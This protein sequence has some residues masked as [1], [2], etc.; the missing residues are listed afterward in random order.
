M[1]SNLY[2]SL[3]LSVIAATL[4]LG[5][6]LA[7]SAPPAAAAESAEARSLN[8]LR[9][10]VVNLLNGLVERGVITR[11]QAEQMVRDAQTAATASEAQ[12]QARDQAEQGAVRV[13]YVPEIVKQ[14]IRKQVKEDLAAEVSK[15]VVE[16]A[17]SEGWGVPAALPDW[18]RRMRWYGDMRL[19]GQ[20]DLFADDNATLTYIDFQRV[21][22][23]GGIGR[24]GLSAFSNTTEERYRMRARLRLGFETQLGYGWTMGAR[25]TTGNLRDPVS[26][27]QTL[28]NTGARYQST[29]DLAWIE[30][31][32]NSATARH[33]FTTTG[34][35]TRN[36]WFAASDLVWDQDLNFEGVSANYRLGL[37]RDDPY[38]HFAYLTVGAF[39]LQEVE[40]ARDKWLLGGQA[41]FDWKFAT[42][43]RLR[44]GA[45]YY[46]Y[47]NTEG[48]RNAFDSTLLDYTAPQFV[49]RGNT[50]FDIRSDN[51]SNTNLF[52]L[53]ASYKL[54]DVS[55]VYDWRLNPEYRLSLGADYV[56]NVGYDE[57]EVRARTGFSVPA[58]V[59]G[60][61]GEVAFG[62]AV[63]ARVNGWR[64][65]AG[66]RYLERDA[67]LDAFTDSDFRLGGTDTKGYYVGG[68]FYF[69]PRVF[70]RLKYLSANEIDGPPL[71]IDN[72]QL[73]LTASF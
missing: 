43:S 23:A 33:V 14:E 24:A 17:T 40:L 52:A 39:P 41:G 35:R 2:P 67:V 50:L 29:F 58:R 42:G 28:G 70:A 60:Y 19:R 46:G 55:V 26:T 37:M 22:E 18:V 5:A 72:V 62:T 69:S 7:V 34:G 57:A 9:N 12:V 71:G 51:D 68:D 73:D 48:A 3:R 53:A 20:G 1:R 36:P 38:A 54:V 6:L 25:I 65:F 10:T 66:Y 21:N 15:S 44:F 45:G 31:T 16:T 27:N 8:E 59:D 30:W 13:P 49:Q 64:V 63:A 4:A 61:Q 11:A 32:H 56:R 47:R